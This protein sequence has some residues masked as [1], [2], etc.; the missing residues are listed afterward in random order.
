[1]TEP[2]AAEVAAAERW[3]H[4]Q[5]LPW[6][7]DG[8]RGRVTVLTSP[9]RVVPVVVA[10]AV[11]GC[12][13]GW[14]VYGASGDGL[15]ATLTGTV[16]LL[17]ALLGY[18][19]GPLRGTSMALWAAG[20]MG[21][22]LDLLLPLV[23]RALPLLLLFM[24][25]LFINTEV[26]QVCS[27]LD[28]ASLWAV[29]LLFVAV[30]VGFLLSRLPEEVRRVEAAVG[31]ES[32]QRACA[33]TPLAAAAGTVEPDHEPLHRAERANL[34][35]VLLVAQALQVLL[36]ALA[37]FAFFIGFGLLAISDTVVRAWVGSPPHLLRW[38]TIGVGLPVSN[39]L[40]QVSVFLSGFAG[41]YFTV[42]AVSDATYRQQFF[43]ALDSELE[44]AVAVRAVYRALLGR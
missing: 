21:R 30:A 36:L 11:A 22:S 39:E 15:A 17:L 28:R 23:A 16:V 35:L 44:R 10:A 42:Y 4:A 33:G 38:D 14:L 18:A 41:L 3:L 29:V 31:A 25:F 2:T 19:A 34:V 7:V 24:T 43:A 20:R 5:G 12:V 8:I 27:A 1:V 32:V 6:F 13:V 26:W 9:R 37:V 40:F